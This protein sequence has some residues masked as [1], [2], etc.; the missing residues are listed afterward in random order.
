MNALSV[1]MLFLFLVA[2][3]VGLAQERIDVVH[4]KNG[5]VLKGVIIENV[6]NDYVRIELQGGSI[7]TVKYADIL[8]F[9]KENV[10]SPASTQPQTSTMTGRTEELIQKLRYYEQEKKN[11]AVAA[12][13][14]LLLTST[15]HAY[16]G[17][18]GRGL[19]FTVLRVGGYYLLFTELSSRRETSSVGLLAYLVGTVV[20]ALDAAWEVDRYNEKLFDRIMNN[21]TFGVSIVPH[22]NGAQLQISYNF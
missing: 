22:G 4:L 11:P 6:P 2:L 3:H 16:A 1:T 15:G 10:S 13:L 9:T 8:K 21:R 17:N 19:L 20:E 18:W 5:D 12:Y 7:F 14:S